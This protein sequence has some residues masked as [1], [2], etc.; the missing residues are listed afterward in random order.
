MATREASTNYYKVLMEEED[1]PHII[2]LQNIILS[3]ETD[4]LNLILLVN[5]KPF[6]LTNDKRVLYN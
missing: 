5:F 3:H 6:G 1:L 4:D 2:Y